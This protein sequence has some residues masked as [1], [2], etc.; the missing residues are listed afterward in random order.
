MK[1]FKS[2]TSVG[3]LRASF[4]TVG[5]LIAKEQ[6]GWKMWKEYSKTIDETK[7]VYLCHELDYDN[8]YNHS[9][10]LLKTL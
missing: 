9:K 6:Q 8:I 2:I 3:E 10:V 7:H 5:F 4:V 1:E